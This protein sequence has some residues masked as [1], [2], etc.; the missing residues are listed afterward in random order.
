MLSLFK[1]QSKPF[2]LLA[3][4]LTVLIAAPVFAQ[5][6]E[7]NISNGVSIQQLAATQQQVEAQTIARQRQSASTQS[8]SLIAQAGNAN[9]AANYTLNSKYAGVLA[10]Q[11]G[12]GNIS[13]ASIVDSPGSSVAQ[14]QIGNDNTSRVGVMGGQD[15]SVATVQISNSNA[16]SIGLL[17][18][19]G[20]QVVY[21]S[22]KSGYRGVVI[23]KD[24]P[25]GT[26]IH[27]D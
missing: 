12:D 27:L 18:S 2:A 3:A 22:A 4:A 19:R 13:S 5:D 9:S 7:F 8:T 16:I 11:L 25:K 10:Y 21:G 24:A 14:I 15:N 26:I 17:N 6:F 20:T 1:H 23:V